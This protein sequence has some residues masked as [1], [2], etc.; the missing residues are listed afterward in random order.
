MSI[1]LQCD[2]LL[3]NMAGTVYGEPVKV[4]HPKLI[5]PVGFE[6]PV[7]PVQRTGCL[8]VTNGGEHVV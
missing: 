1:I 7:D 2:G 3:G 5:G 6:H 4:G 8:G